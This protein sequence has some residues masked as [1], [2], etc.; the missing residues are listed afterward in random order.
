MN[1]LDNINSF[2]V[3][4]GPWI[5]AS[6]IPTIMTGLTLSAKTADAAS[7]V[8]K[9]W[10]YIKQVMNFLSWATHKDVPGTFQAPL[11]LGKLRKKPT[12]GAALLLVFLL[13]PNSGCS[14]FKSGTSAIASDIIDCAKAEG[15]SLKD[16]R[17]LIVLALD[18]AAKI[19]SVIKGGESALET[20]VTDLIKEYG[21]PIVAC[22]LR[23]TLPG[24]GA[25]MLSAEDMVT[26]KVIDNHKW[27]FEG[28]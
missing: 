9:I 16:G 27:K 4:Y 21:E 8:E 13:S 17:S 18:I 28:D 23:D 19:S 5:G 24:T 12:T 14:W 1:I 6:L 10:G 2:W 11:K 26:L 7:A 20:A 22:V 3:T 25:P 15:Q